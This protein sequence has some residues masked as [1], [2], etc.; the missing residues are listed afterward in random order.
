M[1]AVKDQLYKSNQNIVYLGNFVDAGLKRASLP[2]PILNYYEMDAPAIAI[3]YLFYLNHFIPIKSTG[4][5]SKH[6]GMS[7]LPTY[8]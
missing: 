6:A 3:E 7:F 4:S 8:R 5:Y 1:G 2:F